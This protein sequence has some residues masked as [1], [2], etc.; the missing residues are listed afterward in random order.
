MAEARARYGQRDFQDI[1]KDFIEKYK[2]EEYPKILIVTDMLLTGFD[3]SALQTM[4]LDK[5]LKEHRLLQAV[6]RT[7]R[8]YKGIKEAGM[9][10][11]YVGVL[12]EFK[13]ALAMYSRDDIQGAILDIKALEEEFLQ[14]LKDTLVIFL[15]VPQDFSRDSLYKAFELITS[16][17]QVEET[18]QSNY[19]AVRKLF[20][21]LGSEEVKLEFLTQYKWVSA[22]YTFYQKLARQSSV[23]DNLVR[24]YLKKTIQFAHQSTEIKEL[25]KELPVFVFDEFYLEKLE[26]KVKSREEKAANIL[27]TLNRFVLV[28]RHKNPVFESIAEKVERLL[29]LWKEKKKNY[30]LIFTEGTEAIRDMH[31]MLARQKALNFSDMEYAVLIELEKKV[32]EAKELVNQIKDFS[33]KIKPSLFSG[34][35]HQVTAKKEVE[36]EVRRFVRGL[37]SQY[38][39]SFEE[40]NKLHNTLVE[41]IKNYGT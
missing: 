39:L 24:K 3:V 34:W 21:L 6:A 32:P 5:P 15:E 11:D 29:K 19:K 23:E 18:F 10:I 9:I 37:K 27:F 36:R 40:M 38:R 14:K 4:Y 28:D 7:N 22:V 30:E 25:E 31:K 16:D 8:P 17:K 41:C 2:E 26:E 1:R 35:I 33:I 12:K 13:R 20:E